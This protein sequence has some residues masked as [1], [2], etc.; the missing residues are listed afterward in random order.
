[1]GYVADCST[2]TCCLTVTDK[3][4]KE[5]DKAHLGGMAFLDLKKAFDM[6]NQDILLHKL[7]LTSV[8]D[9]SLQWF[10]HI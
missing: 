2:E 9:A 8:S 10:A 4:Q 7:S 3:T 1:M 6:V 5:R